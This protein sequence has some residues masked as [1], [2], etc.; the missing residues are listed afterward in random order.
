MVNMKK[1]WIFFFTIFAMSQAMCVPITWGT[2]V[3]LSVTATNA[4]DPQIVMDSNGNATAAWVENGV[5]NTTTQPSGGSWGTVTT[6]SGSGASHPRLTVD[7][8][9]NV[10]AVWVESTMIVTS[11]IKPFGS[12]WGSSSALSDTGAS[13]VE[14]GVNSATGDLIAVWV[15]SGFIET[16]TKLSGNAWGLVSLLSPPSSD[17]PKVAVNGGTAA[18]IWHTNGVT[19]SIQATTSLVGGTWKQAQVISSIG[20]SHTS[21]TVAVDINGNVQAVW[22]Q[23]NFAGINYANVA[24]GGS[25]LLAGTTNWSAP[26]AISDQGTHNPAN[27]ALHV[28]CDTVGNTTA[29]WSNVYVQNLFNVESAILP[30]GESW[31]FPVPLDLSDLYGYTVD[32]AVD[33]YGNAVAVYMSFNGATFVNILNTESNIAGVL[34]NF[35]SIPVTISQGTS[36]GFPRVAST[37]TGTTVNAVSVWIN[38]NGTNNQIQAST[39]SKTVLLP[40][41]NPAVVQNVINWGVFQDYYNTF[42]WTASLDPNTTEYIVY[43]NGL[44]YQ[45]V[46]ASVTQIIDHNTVQNG[47]VVYGVAAEDNSHGIS[48][49][50]TKSFP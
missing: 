17:Q 7:A 27:L 47:P 29:V 4:T 16:A 34:Q 11:A 9:G 28:A 22:F 3:T 1:I 25:T 26:V 41:S 36:N 31:G 43:R 50:V 10:A 19:D 18:I 23:Y 42:S 30:V 24:V 45:K 14:L 46:D 8:A 15:R 38:N 40:P 2:P 6:L 49:I 21:P 20:I 12:S 35:W 32:V 37:L 39:G 44:F 33:G 13:V 48:P 5:V